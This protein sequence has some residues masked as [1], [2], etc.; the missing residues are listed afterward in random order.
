M[1]EVKF[2]TW[3]GAVRTAAAA[4]VG[5][6]ETPPF[7]GVPLSIAITFR[8][9]RPPGHWGKGR[10]AGRL[11]PSAPL[12]PRGKPDIDKLARS[13]LDSLTG[14]VFDD[15]ARVA[16]LLLPRSTPRRGR[17]A[18]ASRSASCGARRSTRPSAARGRH[19][20]PPGRSSRP[21]MLDAV[22]RQHAEPAK[23]AFTALCD[24]LLAD[25]ERRDAP[26]VPP[27][28]ETN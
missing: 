24:E 2:D 5:A 20:D 11:V 18:R 7:V 16:A 28:T 6:R 26:G 12:F 25:V 22:S 23:R 3:N 14:I 15:D 1:A 9:A 10:N 8:I 17:R 13:T 27:S 4:A 21:A 19:D